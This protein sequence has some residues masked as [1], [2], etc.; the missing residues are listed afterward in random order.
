MQVIEALE[1]AFKAIDAE[2]IAKN[3]QKP[4]A[5]EPI[6]ENIEEIT[7]LYEEL[8][9]E[10]REQRENAKNLAMVME[11]QS[12]TALQPP[13]ITTAH[14]TVDEP[15]YQVP[16]S[17]EPYY[18]VPKAKP[19]PLYENVEIFYPT[20]A[21]NQRLSSTGDKPMEPPKEKPPPPPVGSQ[22]S[23]DDDDDD[24]TTT[25]T[26]PAQLDP[27]K[28]V[29][30]TKRIKKELRNKRTSFLGIEGTAVDEIV[31]SVAPPPD[32]ASLHQEEKRLE[33]LL[34]HQ[35]QT[36]NGHMFDSSDANTS[37]SET[38][39]RQ[40]SDLIT[41]S[42]EPDDDYVTLRK[43]AD[44]DVYEMCPNGLQPPTTVEQQQQHRQL[45]VQQEME[46]MRSLE[47]QI[48]EQEEVLRVERELLQLE[49]EEL[50]RQ[51]ENLL[52]RENLARQ[53]LANGSKMLM[54]SAMGQSL[55]NINT[56]CNNNHYV[57]VPTRRYKA[58]I[59]PTNTNYRQSMPNLP[60]AI[61]HMDFIVP[62]QQRIPPPIPPAK[63]MRLAQV[64]AAAKINRM[65]RDRPEIMHSRN[66]SAPIRSDQHPPQ[67]ADEFVQL[68]TPQAVASSSSY[69]NMSRHTL[70]ALSAAPKP[71]LQDEWV[72]HHHPQVRNK[73]DY[74]N[75]MP[76][77]SGGANC[78]RRFD[79][80]KEFVGESWKL[81]QQQQQQHT[82]KSEPQN[83]NYNKHWLIQEAEQ[84]R[85]DQQ[86]G[87]RPSTNGWMQR[88]GSGDNKPLPDAIIQ[89]LTQR[90]QNRLPVAD[91]KRFV[92]IYCLV[93]FRITFI[94][95]SILVGPHKTIY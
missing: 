2:P 56:H 6:Y 58:T 29:N 60:E 1:L 24:T 38:H 69:G 7:A 80:T 47:D 89:T 79:D 59:G 13:T 40:C 17:L 43:K 88:K 35:Q 83:F 64:A 25:A 77:E 37:S 87:V 30:S 10:E 52:L 73:S 72:H 33:E 21:N 34:Y 84:L 93:S 78:L 61:N 8:E 3:T 49:E 18:E 11:H 12:K 31:F 53:E 54:S 75:V 66:H 20:S 76:M 28:R 55:Q 22:A 36:G 32:I 5:N 42:E 70:H 92:T 62:P 51:Q 16:R 9:H 44:T 46:R 14:S 23:T 85:M 71:K 82:R 15:H 26:K 45:T 41:S 91:R 39:S 50:K 90:V 63:P 94:F 65:Q 95:C 57:N 4:I 68:R 67:A 86:R 81:K 74:V 19:I 48:S 27:M